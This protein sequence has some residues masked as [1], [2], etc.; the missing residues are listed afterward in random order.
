[1]IEVVGKILNK[2][3][4]DLSD[5]AQGCKRW[6]MV[7][8]ALAIIAGILALWYNILVSV[9]EV[10]FVPALIAEIRQRGIM[11]KER[12]RLVEASGKLLEGAKNQ[13]LTQEKLRREKLS[14]RLGRL[15]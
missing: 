10:I 5:D 1:M 14:E 6:I 11:N 9:A 12:A 4:Q 3:W 2:A 7:W 13:L 8:A 15:K